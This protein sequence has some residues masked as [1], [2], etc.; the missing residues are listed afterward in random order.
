MYAHLIEVNGFKSAI[1]G[2]RSAWGSWDGSD[3]NFSVVYA[4]GVPKLGTKDLKLLRGLSQAGDDEGKG[5]RCVHATITVKG[6]LKWLS[7]LDTYK[8]GSTKNST[9]IMHSV[10]KR[11]LTLKDFETSHLTNENKLM[12]SNIIRRLN[13][14]I[15][16]YQLCISRARTGG[17]DSDRWYEKARALERN[18][19]D[20]L[21][22]C[23]LQQ[24][25]YQ[26]SYQTL[27]HIY[28][29]RKNH[30]LVE[31]REF[32]EFIE[33]LPYFKVIYGEPEDDE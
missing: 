11:E 22:E 1:H 15:R 29:A 28:Q 2:A 30:K 24:A 16:E 14:Y 18:I 25:D 32:C 7:Q 12:L 5:M 10:T 21:P 13:K 20:M 26:F 9:S 27:N 33:G 4:D 19:F 6:P 17:K 8:V 23:Y 31:W 3:T